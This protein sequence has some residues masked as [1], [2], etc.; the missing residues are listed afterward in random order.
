[1]KLVNELKKGIIEELREMKIYNLID[2]A[3]KNH[4]E[5]NFFYD[6]SIVDDKSIESALEN[7]VLAQARRDYDFIKID[8]GGRSRKGIITY[9]DHVLFP[10][11]LAY[12]L[13]KGIFS[14]QEIQ[15]IPFDHGETAE[16]FSK[17]YNVEGILSNLRKKLL[18]PGPPVEIEGYGGCDGCPSCC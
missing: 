4:E 13:Y 7:A 5:L 16:E 9:A 6:K 18:N 2:Y 12:A 1:M 10:E 15:Q 3:R 11:Y 17:G 14:R 8:T